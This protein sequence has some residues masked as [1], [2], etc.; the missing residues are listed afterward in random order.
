MGLAIVLGTGAGCCPPFN[1][2]LRGLFKDKGMPI[3]FKLT[4]GAL[5]GVGVP[6]AIIG[7]PPNGLLTTTGPPRGFKSMIGPLF[8]AGPCTEGTGTG[9]LGPEAGSVVVDG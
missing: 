1:N 3:G 6:V 4:I 8:G 9:E 2:P 7:A 5:L